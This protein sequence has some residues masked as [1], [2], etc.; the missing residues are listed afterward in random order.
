MVAVTG[1][2]K[3]KSIQSFGVEVSQNLLS[4]KTEAITGQY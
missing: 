1:R 2:G 3:K 4:Y